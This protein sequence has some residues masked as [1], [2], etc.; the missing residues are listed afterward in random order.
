MLAFQNTLEARLELPGIAATPEPLGTNS[1][2][3]DLSFNLAERYSPDRTPTGIAGVIQYRSDLFERSSVERIALH[4]ERLLEAAVTD[5][6]QPIG[7]LQLLAPEER[8]QILVDWNNTGWPVPDATLSALFEAQ[9]QRSPQ[10]DALISEQNTLS[11]SELNTKANRLAHFLIAQRIG[12]ETLVALALPRSTD[13]VVGLLAILKAGA[14]Y[15][16]LDPDYPAERLAY[17]LRDA[18]PACVITTTKLSAHLADITTGFLHLDDPST[19]AALARSL[20]TDP[21]DAERTE[22]LTHQHPAYVI[23]TS[24]STG[25]PKGVVVEH[26]SLA[27]KALTL[28]PYFGIGPDF[29]I[30]LLSS[31]AFDPSIDQITVPLVHGATI[32]VVSDTV[33]ESPVQFWNYIVQTG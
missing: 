19:I 15:L 17:I 30:T 23:Y 12:P 27:N 8:K 5:P 11:Y 21:T 28:G 29:R 31:I 18:Q 10:A 2:K 3:F 7:C 20:D 16:P 32:V 13:M 26:S 1:A 22:P 4:L 14:A 25:S 9:V 33:R 24:G 6:A